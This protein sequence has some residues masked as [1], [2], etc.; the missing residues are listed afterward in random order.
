[1][2]L[3]SFLKLKSKS[4]TKWD[5]WQFR[6]Q[7]NISAYELSSILTGLDASLFN[8]LPKEILFPEGKA[9]SDFLEVKEAGRHF[10]RT[11][12]GDVIE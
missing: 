10:V 6:P 7:A 8:I 3:L 9:P 4:A 11:P 2:G 5:A 12:E 1:M